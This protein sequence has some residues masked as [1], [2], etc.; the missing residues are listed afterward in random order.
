MHSIPDPGANAEAIFLFFLI[1]LE[2]RL[3]DLVKVAFHGLQILLQILQMA[4][5]NLNLKNK[6]SMKF[7]G[8]IK[9][10]KGQNPLPQR[11]KFATS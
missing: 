10:K 4:F 6:G 2:K 5:H 7:Q 9:A 3:L 8:Q 11:S 1:F